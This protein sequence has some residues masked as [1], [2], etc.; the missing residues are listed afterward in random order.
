MSGEDKIQ[1]NTPGP[2]GVQGVKM[3]AYIGSKIIQAEPMTEK[4]FLVNYKGKTYKELDDHREDI[5]GYHVVYPNPDG[6]YY[7]S[8]SPENVFLTAYRPVTEYEARII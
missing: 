8:W 3:P 1:G 4:T 7:D 5:A 6:S 2:G